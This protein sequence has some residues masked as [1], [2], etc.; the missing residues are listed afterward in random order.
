MISNCTE[1]NFYRAFKKDTN[2]KVPRKIWQTSSSLKKGDFAVQLGYGNPVNIEVKTARRRYNDSSEV[3]FVDGVRADR[4]CFVVVRYQ[5]SLYVIPPSIVKKAATPSG[6]IT[7]AEEYSG[8]Y[9]ARINK[10]VIA[11][12][13]KIGSCSLKRGISEALLNA[14]EYERIT[15][16]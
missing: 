4:G 15:S 12:L 8:S 16:R 6:T 13:Q 2:T 14:K 7:L 5:N 11:Q 10:L 1:R 9:K 3:V